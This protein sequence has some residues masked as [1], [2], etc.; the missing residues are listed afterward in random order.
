MS[1]ITDTPKRRRLTP[2]ERAARNAEAL[3]RAQSGSSEKNEAI[4]E[5]WAMDCGYPNPVARVNLL[6]YGA[7]QALGRQ[8]RKGEH[9]CKL[10]TWIP[11]GDAPERGERDEN[12]KLRRQAMRRKLTTVFHEAQTDA[13]T[14]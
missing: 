4:A 3:G 14:T 8:V 5:M 12:G 13:I 1:T 10:E 7:W 11:I 9:G 2:E 6:T